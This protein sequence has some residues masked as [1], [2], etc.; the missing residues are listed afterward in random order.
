[1]AIIVHRIRLHEGVDPARFEAWVR[2]V[3]YTTCPE[4]PSVESFSV[5]RVVA[6]T[7]DLF[8]F[9]EII[10]VTSREEFE[11]DMH[12]EPFRRLVLEFDKVATVVDEVIGERVGEGY[13]SRP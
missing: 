11:R 13:R 12:G 3:D 2:D 1:M 5:Q 8:H 9:F 4:L 7:G 6:G 10:Q